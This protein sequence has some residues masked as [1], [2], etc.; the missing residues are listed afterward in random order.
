MKWNEIMPLQPL[1]QRPPT[2]TKYAHST[3]LFSTIYNA[4]NWGN[5]LYSTLLYRR[6]IDSTLL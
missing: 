6:W 4:Y 2:S 3:L 5:A 1:P